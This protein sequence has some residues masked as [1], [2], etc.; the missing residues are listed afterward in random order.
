MIEAAVVIGAI[1]L[2]DTV[3]RVGRFL[4]RER[5]IAYNDEA[6]HYA[7]I[8]EI[9]RNRH[10]VPRAFSYALV[11]HHSGRYPFLYH[12]LLSFL[13]D[14]FVRGYGGI[15][16][17]LAE[18]AYVAL[19]GAVAY[20]L[21]TRVGLAEPGPLVVGGVA[22]AAAALNPQ[23]WGRSTSSP[24]QIAISPR[25]LGKVLASVSCL[26]LVLALPQS[27]FGLWAGIAILG[28]ALVAL[29]SK[30]GVQAVVLTYIGIALATLRWEPAIYLALGLVLALA[31][32]LGAY[33]DVLTGQVRHL[34]GYYRQIKDTHYMTTGDFTFQVGHIRDLLLHPRWTS[35]RRLSTDPFLRQVS[36]WL[37]QFAVL[38]LVLATNRGFPHASWGTLLLWWLAVDVVVWLLVLHPRLKFIGEGDRYMEY[39][40]NLPL[41]VLAALAL[42][43]L[44]P[45]GVRAVAVV[46][47]IGYPLLFNYLGGLH[48]AGPSVATRIR[49]DLRALATLP[50][51]VV[52]TVPPGAA[53]FVRAAVGRH[54]FVNVS[55]GGLNDATMKQLYDAYPLVDEK[56][57]GLLERYKVDYLV[58]MPET[59]GKLQSHDVSRHKPVFEGEWVRVYRVAEHAPTLT[60]GES[61]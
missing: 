49:S 17:A 28:V 6:P 32:S 55:P 51:G 48:R 9:R 20:L 46:A 47:V 30:F 14:R 58:L 12:W 36:F 53:N 4:A 41:N 25:P 56:I 50:D 37:P 44:E 21:A 13:P 29:T 15:F 54:K 10:R 2:M 43:S 61:G 59:R 27:A 3:A 24:M 57:D 8:T 7:L 11:H 5:D 45:V 42:W 34:I 22:S 52:L 39:S 1:M 35:L 19:H 23:A 33:W 38:A 40:G 31:L 26:A 18:T 16:S 60:A